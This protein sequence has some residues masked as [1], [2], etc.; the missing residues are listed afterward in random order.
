MELLY[1]PRF[2][3]KL[4]EHTP[5]GLTLNPPVQPARPH[6]Q[7]LSETADKEIK[8]SRVLDR[9]PVFCMPASHN[10]LGVLVKQLSP[11]Y[12][13]YRETRN[14]PSPEE[15]TTSQNQIV[16]SNAN[17]DLVKDFPPLRVV[18]TSNLRQSGAVMHSAYLRSIIKR[19]PEAKEYFPPI[20]VKQDLTAY[21]RQLDMFPRDRVRQMR[22]D[23][24]KVR[25]LRPLQS[26]IL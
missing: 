25:P 18:T 24:P 8:K 13:N 12:P 10:S 7:R 11:P 5:C 17:I 22:H 2:G 16:A 21:F 26:T 14:L 15:V 1:W 23:K 9:P 4:K 19:H 3:F 20:S 6:F